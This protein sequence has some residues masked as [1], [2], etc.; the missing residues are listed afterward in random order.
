MHCLVRRCAAAVL[1]MLHS[2]AQ[3]LASSKGFVRYGDSPTA[4]DL[5]HPKTCLYLLRA[6]LSWPQPAQGVRFGSESFIVK[7]Y[8]AGDACHNGASHGQRAQ[9]SCCDMWRQHVPEHQ[10][11]L[12]VAGL[13]VHL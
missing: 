2:T 10:S 4:K 3:W 8:H 12:V 1:Q 5:E 7:A 13:I 11:F 9:G 6:Y